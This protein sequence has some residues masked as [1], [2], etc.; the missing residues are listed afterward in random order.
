MKLTKQ[1]LKEM[2]LKEMNSINEGMLDISNI[3]RNVSRIISDFKRARGAIQVAMITAENPPGGKPDMSNETEGFYWDNKLMQGYIKDDLKTL[4]YNYYPIIGDYGGLENSLMVIVKGNRDEKFKENMIQLGKKYNQDAVVV[5]EKMASTQMN[6]NIDRAQ[7][8]MV[9][10][11]IMLHPTKTGRPNMDFGDYSI[12]DIRTTA[13]KG[14]D[15]QSRD[16][17]YSQAGRKKFIVPF[18]S[19]EEQDLAQD[20]INPFPVGR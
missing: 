10:E 2:I 20:M 7:Y 8:N 19:D 12:D 3:E 17:Y 1:L 11:M 14:P 13:H 9:F 5:G 16:A 15:V 6:P 18:Y 4:G